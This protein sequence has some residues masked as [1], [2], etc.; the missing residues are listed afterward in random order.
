MRRFK[1]YL[2]DFFCLLFP[3]P[4]NACG[5]QLVHG[6]QQI[7]TRC[8]YDLPFT[9]FHLHQENAVAKLF[10][11]RIHCHT[12]MAMLYFRKGSRVQELIHQLKYRSRTDL[13]LRMG[14]MLAERL[15]ASPFYHRADLIIPV[16]LHIKKERKRG[17]NQSRLIA[18]G[19]SRVLQVPVNTS[20]LVRRRNTGTQTKK[21]RYSRFENMKAVFYAPMPE[22]LAA[23]NVILVD[24]VITTGATLESCGQVLLN[25]GVSTLNIAAVAFAE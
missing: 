19:M 8:L 9:D 14:A 3:D 1:Q 12:A 21:N 5:V 17:Y 4:C 7:C 22:E 10:W 6:E 15:A 20:L 25:C 13:G 18:E 24:D 2:Y 23:K 16:P 11:G